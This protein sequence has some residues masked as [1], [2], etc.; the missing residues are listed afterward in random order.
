MALSIEEE[1][2]KS[3]QEQASGQEI[4][5]HPESSQ[6]DQLGS[7]LA[8]IPKSNIGGGLTDKERC[9]SSYLLKLQNLGKELRSD[10]D[11]PS[12]SIKPTWFDEKL[13]NH[14]KSVY[15]RH[16]MGINFAHLSGLLLLVRVDTIYDTL[17]KTGESSTISKLFKRYYHTVKHVKTW[18]EGDIFE[19]NSDAHRSLLIVRGMHNKTSYKLNDKARDTIYNT[20][21]QNNKPEEPRE[22]AKLM[23]KDNNGNDCCENGSSS[24]DNKIHMSEYD[25]MITQFAFVGFI[26]LHADKVG[27]IGDFDQNDMNSLLHFW[28]VIGYYLGAS[29]KLN[30]YSHEFNDVVGLCRAI[31]ADIFKNSLIKNALKSPQGIMSVNVIRAIKFIPMLTFYG[32]MKHLYDILE[33]D[34][35]EI[36]SRKTWFSNLSYTL[37]NLVMTRLLRYKAFRLFNNGLTRLSLY[38]VGYIEEWFSNHLESKYGNQLRI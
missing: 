7:Q 9:Y 8:N 4:K 38:L 22:E 23:E 20:S 36:E 15:E 1:I 12:L 18:Y 10:R 31:E 21:V 27:L 16:F 5:N 33:Y 2:Q 34:T 11:Q 28:R 32:M 13:F 19:E 17:S 29:E 30:L 6:H 35:H 25:I 24:H 26:V 3:S 37:I 14:A